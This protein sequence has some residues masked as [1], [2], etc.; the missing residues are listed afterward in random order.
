MSHKVLLPIKRE[1][2]EKESLDKPSYSPVEDGSKPI[3][4]EEALIYGSSDSFYNIVDPEIKIELDETRPIDENSEIVGLSV[5]N[6][7]Y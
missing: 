7:Q 3:S 2:T 1:S 5:I 6:L 4:I